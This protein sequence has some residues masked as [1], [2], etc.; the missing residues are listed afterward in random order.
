MKQRWS[1]DIAAGLLVTAVGLLLTGAG[2]LFWPT[3]TPIGAGIALLGAAVATFGG[4]E[5]FVTL[6]ET[7][8]AQSP[9]ATS[10]HPQ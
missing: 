2:I 5:Y 4:F 9:T 8:T 7:K 3:L 10:P 6:H 1:N